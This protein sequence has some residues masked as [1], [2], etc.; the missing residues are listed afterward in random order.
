MG[1]SKQATAKDGASGGGGGGT[2]IFK[3]IES[4]TDERY[5][6]AK[7]DIKYETL[8]VAAGGSGGEDSGH[9]GHNS[10][11]HDGQ[12]SN[13]KSL[14]NFTEYSKVTN[15]CQSSCDVGLMGIAQFI[16]FDAKGSFYERA[17]GF[18]RGGYGCG[19]SRDDT[20]ASGGGWCQGSTS[21]QATSWSLDPKAV[22]TD[23]FN[24]GDGSV[25]IKYIK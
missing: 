7:G 20:F 16:E 8:L 25:T 21:N 10:C 4:I 1:T 12:A 17:G 23:G 13:Y 15:D 22:G 2:F 5:Q 11:G 14:N 6:F 24:K 18:S 19:A 3:R 9:E